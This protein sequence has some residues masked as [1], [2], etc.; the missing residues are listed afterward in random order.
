VGKKKPGQRAGL[1]PRAEA[2]HGGAYSL[3]V[4]SVFSY[5]SAARSV[6]NTCAKRK[7]VVCQ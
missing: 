6:S 2:E 7:Q 1:K 3:G 4:V 5:C